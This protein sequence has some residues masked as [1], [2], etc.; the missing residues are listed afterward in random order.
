M[1]CIKPTVTPCLGILWAAES[2]SNNHFVQGV[3]HFSGYPYVSWAEFAETIIYLT[4]AKATVKKIASSKFKTIAMRPK[5]S[6]LNCDSL[7]ST[8]NIKQSSWKTD[9]ENV[10]EDLIKK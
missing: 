9:L 5:N 1:K 8:Y 3:F 10:I 2:N 6:R 7:F 4:K